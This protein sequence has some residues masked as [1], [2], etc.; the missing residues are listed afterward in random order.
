VTTVPVSPG[1][2]TSRTTGSRA[3][4]V[5][6]GG[7]ATRF[8]DG[9]KALAELR[10][11]PLLC[12][13]VDGLCPAVAGVV[14][15]CRRAQLPGFR[16][17]LR[18]ASAVAFAPDPV[19]DRGPAAGLAAGLAPVAAP[20]VALAAVDA[21]FVDPALYEFL[22]GRLGPRGGPDAA[23]PVVD[24]HP[25]PTRAVY[26]VEPAL[27]AAVAAVRAGEASFRAVLDRLE[28]R[29]IAERAVLARTPRRTFTDV[30]TRADLEAA[31][32]AIERDPGS[33]SA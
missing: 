17:V 1:D 23:V 32:D 30:N 25:Q 22:F 33:G 18:G 20:A 6:A 14:V 19:P 28:V 7:Y 2:G 27:R 12:R 29:R 3:G 13:V 21:P 10:G 11:R 9:D 26:R 31:A 15:N 16:R 24:G 4:L 5:L 8:A